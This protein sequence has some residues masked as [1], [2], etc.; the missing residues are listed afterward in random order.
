MNQRNGKQNSYEEESIEENVG[1]AGAGAPRNM[2]EHVGAD[3]RVES[4][5]LPDEYSDENGGQN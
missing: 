1:G 3:E 5:D 2:N 4:G